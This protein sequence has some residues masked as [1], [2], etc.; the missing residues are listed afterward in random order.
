METGFLSLSPVS[1]PQGKGCDMQGGTFMHRDVA[2]LPRH[3]ALEVTPLENQ[4]FVD[5]I[6]CMVGFGQLVSC[7]R[8]ETGLELATIFLRSL[9]P[10][11]IVGIWEGSSTRESYSYLD[12][13]SSL[14]A[15]P[16]FP[17]LHKTEV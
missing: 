15:R 11:I 1:K 9:N 13:T 12:V 7:C 14:A 5:R 2:S 6:S 16:L 8:R 10:I 4:S 3:T 17:N